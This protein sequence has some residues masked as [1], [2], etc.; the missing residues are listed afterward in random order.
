MMNPTIGCSFCVQTF[1]IAEA[2]TTHHT[3]EDEELYHQYSP[4]DFV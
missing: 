4:K 3:K 1:N 2:K